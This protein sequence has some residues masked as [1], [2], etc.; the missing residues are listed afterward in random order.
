MTR[1]R[2]RTDCSWETPAG[3]EFRWEH[4]AI[5]VMMDIRE[6]L[7]RLNATLSCYRVSRMSDDIN[8]LERRVARR[9]PLKPRK[10]KP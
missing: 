6:E 3:A 2:E 4:V 7:K 8:R 1:R 9:Y 5:E 10:A